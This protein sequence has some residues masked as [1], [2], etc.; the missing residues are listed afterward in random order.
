MNELGKAQLRRNWQLARS[1]STEAWEA[2]T[3]AA[4]WAKAVP[5]AAWCALTGRHAWGKWRASSGIFTPPERRY[6]SRCGGSQYRGE[7]PTYEVRVEPGSL[8]PRG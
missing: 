2:V 8:A 6:C 7:T 3:N 4:Y 1:R 5:K